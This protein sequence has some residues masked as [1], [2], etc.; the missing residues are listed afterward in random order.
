MMQF[1]I[2]NKIKTFDEDKDKQLA[3]G[4]KE[5]EK[6]RENG[7]KECSRSKKIELYASKSNKYH[8]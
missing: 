7:N 5:E 4:K 3:I 2:I 6:K 1:I 8:L